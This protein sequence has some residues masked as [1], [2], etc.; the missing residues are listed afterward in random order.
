[1]VLTAEGAEDAEKKT[2]KIIP[3]GR[4]TVFPNSGPS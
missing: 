2:E 3:A 1:M 4:T